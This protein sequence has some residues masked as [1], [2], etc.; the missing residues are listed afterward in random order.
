MSCFV[1]LPSCSDPA[2]WP[3]APPGAASSACFSS[4]TPA[5]NG[6]GA[7]PQPAAGAR[8]CRRDPDVPAYGMRAWP[9]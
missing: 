3:C 9:T 8:P 1:V 5:P 7:R 4:S 6:I 2:G